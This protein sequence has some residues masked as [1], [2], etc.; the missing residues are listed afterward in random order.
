[1][2][3]IRFFRFSWIWVNTLGLCFIASLTWLLYGNYQSG[4]SA[5]WQLAINGVLLSI[6]LVLFYSMIGLFGQAAWIKHIH[7]QVGPRLAKWIYWSPRLAGVTIILFVS[8]FALDVFSEGYTPL[9]MLIGFIMHMLPS[10]ALAIVLALAWRWEWIG[11]VTFLGAAVFFLRF[12]WGDPEGLTGIFLLFSGPMLM[13]AVLFAA[14]W[15]WRADLRAV[16]V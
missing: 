6:P 5:L 11:A 16:R 14:N 15:F 7:Q 4:D 3:T 12:A 8:L 1:M 13:I 2:N 10:F 9:E